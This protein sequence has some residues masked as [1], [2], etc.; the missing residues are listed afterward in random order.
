MYI[1]PGYFGIRFGY[2][3]WLLQWIHLWQLHLQIPKFFC[4]ILR[5][6]NCNKLKN[7]CRL[8]LLTFPNYEF[9]EKWEK[10][11]I[12]EQGIIRIREKQVLK[13][14]S[15]W[16]SF[17]R[18]SWFELFY[19]F[20][21]Q[22]V[23]LIIASIDPIVKYL[24]AKPVGRPCRLHTTIAL[25]NVQISLAKKR[26]ISLWTICRTNSIISVFILRI[27]TIAFKSGSTTLTWI[28]KVQSKTWCN[29]TFK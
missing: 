24:I 11:E 26:W 14:D 5:F 1:F 23:M 17:K 10:Q 6:R 21:Y 27:W 18:A 3:W 8:D 9:C 15:N 19:C 16:A 22:L 28:V 12:Q 29:K 20:L 2:N 25:W 7:A 4:V 13:L